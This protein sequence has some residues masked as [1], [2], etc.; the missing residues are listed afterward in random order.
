MHSCGERPGEFETWKPQLLQLR[1]RMTIEALSRHIRDCHESMQGEEGLSH[2]VIKVLS[3]ASLVPL[4]WVEGW[5]SADDKDG[6]GAPSYCTVYI[7][8]L[9]KHKFR[10][11]YRS[12]WA[13]IR[14]YRF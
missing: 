4:R 1:D 9:F 6:M 12:R 3:V 14:V 10:P 8:L 11:H 2:A 13:E 5:V 7:I